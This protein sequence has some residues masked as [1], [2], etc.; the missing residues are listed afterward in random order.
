LCF[1]SA[2]SWPQTAPLARELAFPAPLRSRRMRRPHSNP[3]AVVVKELNS[4]SFQRNH[5]LGE[6]VG[7]G[8]NGIY[9]ALHALD[10]TQVHL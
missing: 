7:P 4:G 9:E 5:H 8:A 2:T 3:G 10:G 6:G 1:L